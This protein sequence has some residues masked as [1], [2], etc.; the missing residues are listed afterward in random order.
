M[1]TNK[2]LRK[3]IASLPPEKLALL[4]MPVPIDA[5]TMDEMKALIEKKI[6]EQNVGVLV[7]ERGTATMRSG[8][9]FK[10]ALEGL[11]NLMHERC[12]TKLATS[13]EN[14]EALDSHA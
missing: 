7:H 10:A 6:G 1:K 9:R 13:A 4:T 14:A 5:V 3:L 12:A 11:A 8:F 2:N